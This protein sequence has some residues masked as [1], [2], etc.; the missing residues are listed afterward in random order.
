MFSNKACSNDR[1]YRRIAAKQPSLVR[2][3]KTFEETISPMQQV[4]PNAQETRKKVSDP[5]EVAYFTAKHGISAKDAARI[6][7]LHRSDRDSSDRAAYQ[8]KNTL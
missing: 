2:R 4:Q 1:A 8:L 6:I 7:N 5:Y 3:S